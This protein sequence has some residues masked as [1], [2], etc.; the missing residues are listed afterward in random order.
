[1]IKYATVIR[2]YINLGKSPLNAYIEI[3]TK[4]F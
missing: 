2:L 1:M 3:S 4:R